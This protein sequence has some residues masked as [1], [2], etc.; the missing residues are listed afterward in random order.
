L[1]TLRRF[2]AAPVSDGYSNS[3]GLPAVWGYVPD[4]RFIIVVFEEID[5]DTAYVTTAYE[6]PEPRTNRKKKRRK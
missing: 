1:T 3:S 5:E 4:G 2:F 6:V